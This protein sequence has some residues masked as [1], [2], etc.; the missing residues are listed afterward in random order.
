MLLT[1]DNVF[2]ES[3]NI[4]YANGYS[5]TNPTKGEGQRLFIILYSGKEITLHNEV[6]LLVGKS[7]GLTIFPTLPV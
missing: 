2:V 1:T 7:L 4:V 6:A 5:I 3:S